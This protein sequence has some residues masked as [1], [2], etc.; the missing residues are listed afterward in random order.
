MY[1]R[2]R[3][4]SHL[5]MMGISQNDTM[6]LG[7]LQNCG[8]KS[9]SRSASFNAIYKLFWYENNRMEGIKSLH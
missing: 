7:I 5:K 4:F 8:D 6:T 2:L 3:D 1:I 9:S